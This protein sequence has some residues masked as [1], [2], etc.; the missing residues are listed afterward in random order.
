MRLICMSIKFCLILPA[1]DSMESFVVPFRAIQQPLLWVKYFVYI[2]IAFEQ[3]RGISLFWVITVLAKRS[4][5]FY[6]HVY[7]A[8]WQIYSA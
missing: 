6:I 5:W 4:R 3:W 8:P 2:C 1:F 7:G